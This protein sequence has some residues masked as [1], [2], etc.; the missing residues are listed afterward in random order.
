[1]LKRI[2]NVVCICL[3]VSIV[4]LSM[5]PP[6][7]VSA[8]NEDGKLKMHSVK[9]TKNIFCTR[10]WSYSNHEISE[11]TDSNGYIYLWEIYEI[12]AP[13][14][15]YSSWV[16]Q[17][18]VYK[19]TGNPT[20]LTTCSATSGTGWTEVF[21]YLWDGSDGYGGMYTSRTDLKYTD[22]DL[23]LKDWYSFQVDSSIKSNT[24]Y[25]TIDSLV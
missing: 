5:Y 14:Y 13:S 18:Y 16:Y 3:L 25:K 2:L 21:D 20:P 23:C 8:G 12:D 17:R 4:W 11:K 19:N 1:M 10:T 22:V 6:I 15:C 7:N 24:Y 9:A